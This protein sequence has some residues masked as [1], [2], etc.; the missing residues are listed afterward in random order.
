[1]KLGISMACYRWEVY[2]PLRRD[3]ATYAHLGNPMPYESSMPN[4]VPESQEIQW[5]L[6][7]SAELGI[8]CFYG[9]WPLLDDPKYRDE[10]RSLL[11]ELDIEW[12]H[13]GTFDWVA[14][15]S[16]ADEE[17]ERFNRQLEIAS[18]LGSKIVDLTHSGTTRNNH[19][20]KDPRI[21][22]QIE[23][24]IDNFRRVASLAEKNGVIAAMENHLD[25][26]CS[27]IAQVIDAVASPWVRMMLDTGNSIGVI[28]DPVDAAKAV[29]KYTVMV[30]FKDYRMQAMSVDGVPRIFLAPLGRGQVDLDTIL[31]TLQAE[32]PD[33]DHLPLCLESIGPW[34]Q[35]SDMWVQ[36]NIKYIKERFGGYLT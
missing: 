36:A 31:E 20:S 17:L 34:E 6:R 23:I 16:S 21:E 27:E 26:R 10:I 14:E 25:Y 12:L 2:P 22:R 9:D 7:R 1:M 29:A 33:P 24:M 5:L 30:H 35:D 11:T 4:G 8:R 19:F 15:G 3:T 13:A 18:D 28:E 32:A